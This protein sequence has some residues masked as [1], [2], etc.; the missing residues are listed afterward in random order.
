MDGTIGVLQATLLFLVVLGRS[1]GYFKIPFGTQES[2]PW[3][4]HNV[5]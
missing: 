5:C 2:P 1:G 4:I 3:M